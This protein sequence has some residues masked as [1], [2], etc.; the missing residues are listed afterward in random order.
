MTNH[1]KEQIGLGALLK[2][3]SNDMLTPV[4][5]LVFN[6]PDTTKKIFEAIR[7]AQPKKL[8]VVADG[9]R[10]EQPGEV[11]RCTEVRS[12]INTVDWECDVLTNYS[13]T[14]L[15]CKQR[16]SSGLDWAFSLVEEAII[17]ED[18]CLP[19]PSFF[20]FCEEMLE[21]Y[22]HDE[23][24]MMISGTN[25]LEEWKSDLQSY[26]FSYYGGIW[27]WASW[28]RAWQYYDIE[29]SLWSSPEIK[30]RIRDVLVDKEQY[31][32]N[33]QAFDASYQGKIDAWGYRWRFARLIQSGLSIVPAVNLVSNIG[34]RDDATHTKTQRSD[35]AEI[36]THQ[37]QFPPKSSHFTV[38][39]RDY[40][41]KIFEKNTKKP[42]ILTRIK[43]KLR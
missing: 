41:R 15:G 25:M 22:R 39:D 23:R 11:E 10:L 18:D 12:L 21:M 29:M 43:N 2:Q 20:R 28:R 9:A 13:E 36:T 32:S 35:L 7:Q 5:F 42:P 34:F 17:L 24:V 3:M 16:V 40:D 19:D 38:V 31:Q 14:N 37:F 33:K 8:L 4:V 27:G 1:S 30:E 26:H 6:R